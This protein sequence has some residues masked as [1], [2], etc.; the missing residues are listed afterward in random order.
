MRYAINFY[1]NCSILNEVDEIIIKYSSNKDLELINYATNKIKQEQR[2][3]VEIVDNNTI[4]IQDNLEIFLKTYEC[5]PNLTFMIP[6]DYNFYNVFKENKLPLF[7]N[8]STTTI[9]GV[10]SQI[11]AG[12]SDIFLT[13]ELCFS[14][15]NI[16]EICHKYNINI[17]TFANIAQSTSFI[18]DQNGLRQF[19]IRPEDLSDYENYI[20]IIQFA[21]D[22]SKQE[23]YYNIY[24]KDK[25]WNGYINDIIIDLNEPDIKNNCLLPDFGK[26]RINCGKKC[27][28]EKCSFCDINKNIGNQLKDLNIN[29]QGREAVIDV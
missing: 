5:H 19:F 10:Y 11:M 20:D 29:I 9:G 7:F 1:K 28:F 22:I 24:K 27:V 26:Q 16:S 8:I 13:A 12:V 14:L 18:K 21:G 15:K 6:L 25:V 3:V 17:R 23:T 2:L 4:N